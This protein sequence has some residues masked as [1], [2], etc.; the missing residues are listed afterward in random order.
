MPTAEPVPP[1]PGPT[2]GSASGPTPGSTPGPTARPTV[3]VEVVGLVK[4]YGPVTAV[5]GLD[6]TAPIGA[7]TAV[8]GPN[9]A[10]KTT[11]LEV[12]EGYRRPDAGQVRVL[13]LDPHGPTGRS[14]G[15]GRAG[16]REALCR[17]VGVMLQEG[18]VYGSVSADQALRHAAALYANPQPVDRLLERLGLLAC[19]RTPYRRLSGGQQRRVGLALALVGRPEL[20]FLDEPSAGLDPQARLAVADLV[21]LLRTDGASVVLTTHDMAEAEELAQ[22]VVIVDAGRVVAAGSPADLVGANGGASVVRF[23][24]D[25]GLDTGSLATALGSAGAGPPVV[26]ETGPG[27]YEVVGAL[28]PAAPARVTAWCAERGLAPTQ[29]SLRPRS[30][31]DVFLELT[32]R[33]LRP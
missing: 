9:G 12:C 8:L 13:G 11:T 4:R 30:L 3:A 6:L 29:L 2:P 28:D 10:G 24:C 17:R 18:G 1:T 26:R 16:G 14:G 33:E 22:Y 7:V 23:D 31:N 21:R 19:A 25:P 32:G 5:D 20:V 27:H 15:G